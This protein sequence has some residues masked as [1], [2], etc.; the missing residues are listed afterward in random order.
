MAVRIEIERG[1]SAEK[2]RK[3]FAFRAP[4][5]RLEGA[6]RSHYDVSSDGERFLLAEG[7]DDPASYRLH[8]VLNWGEEL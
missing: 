5:P 4:L 7:G 6:Y 8:V 3:L 2:P 1:I